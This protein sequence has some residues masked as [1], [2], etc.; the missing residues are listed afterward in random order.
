MNP[1]ERI[2]AR[3]RRGVARAGAKTGTGQPLTGTITRRGK[4]DTTTYPPTPGIDKNYHFV[5]MFS[6]FGV[7]DYQRLE[8]TSRD[9]K[10]IVTR[11]VRADDGAEIEPSNGDT[12]TIVGKTYHI[13]NIDATAQGGVALMWKCQCRNVDA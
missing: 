10:V 12:V 6:E 5:G 1:G 9:M 8:I 4:A 13:Q 3:V 11:P 7:S 2:A